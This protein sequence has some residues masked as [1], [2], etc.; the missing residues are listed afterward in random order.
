MPVMKS[1]IEQI[2]DVL[3]AR[4]A[5][6]ALKDRGVQ[7]TEGPGGSVVVVDGLK[8]YEGL[9]AVPDEAVRALIRDSIAEWEK[10]AK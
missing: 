10:T 9:E 7:L 2:N 3:Q 1:M 4:L 5:A 6:G 8:S